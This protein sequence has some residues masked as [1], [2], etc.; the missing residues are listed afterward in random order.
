MNTGE[1]IQSGIIESYVLG[2]ATPAEATELE[3]LM[4]QYPEI[5]EAV[6]AFEISLEKAAFENAVTPKAST[7]EQLF[8]NLSNEFV[9]TPV[10]SI[11]PN[12]ALASIK[13]LRYASA[14]A[15]VLLLVS[16]ALNVFLYNKYNEADGKYRTALL[17]NNT[18]TAQNDAFKTSFQI[19]TDSSFKQV[20]MPDITGKQNMLATV[21]WDSKSK[22]VYLLANNLP[23]L[24]KGKQYQLWAIV[25]GQPVD[26]GVMSNCTG[27][28][29][30]KNIPQASMFAITVEKEG[31]SELPTLTAMVVAGKV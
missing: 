17:Q 5:K 10:H 12:T 3:L 29:K 21:Y 30:M 9:A 20:P 15:V 26:A 31:G 4:Q 7:R 6:T 8:T 19:T 1:Y 23:S 18:L 14:A 22:D 24:E 27:L 2:L 13:W 28:C 11:A 16:S 25:N